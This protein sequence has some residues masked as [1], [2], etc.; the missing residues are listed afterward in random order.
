METGTHVEF[1]LAGILGGGA[2]RSEA[3]RSSERRD[4]ER[5]RESLDIEISTVQSTLAL[6]GKTREAK[7]TKTTMTTMTTTTMKKKMTTTR[8][9]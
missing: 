8:G 1:M 5:A 2:G 7:T 4:R 9:L 3:L 6:E